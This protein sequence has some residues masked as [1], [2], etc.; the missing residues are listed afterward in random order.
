MAAEGE[1]TVSMAVDDLLAQAPAA[2]Q[3]SDDG[4]VPTAVVDD[5]DLLLRLLLGLDLQPALVGR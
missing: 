2:L 4:P 3:P 1:A 5:P